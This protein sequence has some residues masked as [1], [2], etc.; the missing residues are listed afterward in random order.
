MA[1]TSEARVSAIERGWARLAPAVPLGRLAV[2]RTL[3]YLFVIG[4]IT[5]FTGWARTRSTVPTDVYQP[6]L[7]ARLVRLPAPGPLLVDVVF[8]ALLAGALVGI[9][10]KLPRVAGALVAVL[11]FEWLI[12]V[13]SY[14]KVDHDR[15]GLLVALA[16]LPTAGRA[17]YGDRRL[18]ERAGWVLRFTQIAVILTYFLSSVAKLRFGGPQWLVGATL[19]RAVIRRGT[20][21]GHLM[22][23]VPH[24]M[25]VSQFIIVAF[26]LS[27][28]LIF[29]TRG[30]L[31]LLA[32]A[33]LYA[34]HVLVF[35]TI[36]ISFLAHMVAMTS[37]L[38]LERLWPGTWTR[39]R[40]ARRRPEVA[41]A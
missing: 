19:A 21:F 26:E 16:T 7:V 3:I 18:S 41:V 33:G 6:L 22:L 37:F 14:G 32:V 8:W 20:E 9:T 28:P 25:V 35:A 2:F 17:A 5:T 36:T 38:P 40:W 1:L 27:S 12:I 34:F 4:D 39:G 11:Y 30:R 10:G 31:R 24:L 15:F 29:L 23:G 13:M